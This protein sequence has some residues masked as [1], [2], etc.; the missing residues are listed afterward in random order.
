MATLTKPLLVTVDVEDHGSATHEPRFG[1]ALQPLLAMLDEMD[2]RA[3]FFVVGELA[4]TWADELKALADAGHEIGLHGLTHRFLEELGPKRLAD[5]L[6]EGRSVLTD[7]VGTEPTGFRAPYFGLT[8]ATPWAP[9]VIKDAGFTY[10][11]SVLP[12]WNPQAGFAGAPKQPFKWANGLIE[13]P[14]PVL[15]LGP[16]GLPVLG[17]A[18]L[19][20]VPSFVVGL[21]E[22]ITRA[23]ARWVYAHPYD[24][25]TEEPFNRRPGQSLVVA[26]LLF[27]RRKLMLERVRR[28]SGPGASTLAD[29]ASDE[30]FTRHLP[31]FQPTTEKQR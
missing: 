24:F 13:F 20:L 4:P 14:S 6:A 10:S 9:E 26:K 29:L 15:A 18:Y 2:V 30:S 27:A 28:L 23:D 7:L 22:R 12:V 17:G 25:D 8:K 31:I 16:F 5:E 1:E 21:A 3:T 19:R 11:S